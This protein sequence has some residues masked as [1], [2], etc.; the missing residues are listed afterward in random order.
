M[1]QLASVLPGSNGD[2]IKGL[3]GLLEKLKGKIAI[4][5]FGMKKVDVEKAAEMAVANPYTNPRVVESG[6]VSELNRRCWAGEEART[7]S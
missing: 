3:N 7:D 2:A 1:E 4:K 5:D 6:L